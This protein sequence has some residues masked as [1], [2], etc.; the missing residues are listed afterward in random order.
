M[1]KGINSLWFISLLNKT[2]A[3]QRLVRFG[4]AKDLDDVHWGFEEPGFGDDKNR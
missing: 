3:E 1:K 4:K 2:E